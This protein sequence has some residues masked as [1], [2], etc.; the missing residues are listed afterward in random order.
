MSGGCFAVFTSTRKS[1]EHAFL[2]LVQRVEVAMQQRDGRQTNVNDDIGVSIYGG[3]D[4]CLG[5]CSPG[6]WLS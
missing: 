1:C 6:R 5:R 3:R 4:Y 2:F